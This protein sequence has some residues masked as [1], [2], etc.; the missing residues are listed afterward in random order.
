MLHREGRCVYR[1]CVPALHVCE[2]HIGLWLFLALTLEF[3]T[4]VSALCIWGHVSGSYNAGQHSF[5][6]STLSACECNAVSCIRPLCGHPAMIF[7]V[8]DGIGRKHTKYA[9]LVGRV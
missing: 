6:L 9:E 1:L 5:Q 2:T 8:R 7:A 3:V 4:L